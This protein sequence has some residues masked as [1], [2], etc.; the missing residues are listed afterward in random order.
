MGKVYRAQK[1]PNKDKKQAVEDENKMLHNSHIS[2]AEM[3][4][5]AQIM[6]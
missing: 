1:E 6:N 4:H 2:D 5:I 3:E